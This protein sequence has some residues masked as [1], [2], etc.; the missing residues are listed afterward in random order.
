[1]TNLHKINKL[2]F[3]LRC[4][5]SGLGTV[6]KEEQN[7]KT[8]VLLAAFTLLAGVAIQISKIEMIVVIICITIVLTT[9]IINTAIEDLCDK[10]EP[11]HDKT[12]GKIKDIM[13]GSV[14]IAS[15]SSLVVGAIIFVPKIFA[16]I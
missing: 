3:S 11:H 12:I 16:L 6:F 8:E 7:F 2:F 4:A 10:V 5:L 13:A 1:M 15:V 14:L 9:E